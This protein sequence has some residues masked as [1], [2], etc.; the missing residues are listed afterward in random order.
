M[1][2]DE[3]LVQIECDS[4]KC[5]G[6]INEFLEQGK[7]PFVIIGDYA[8]SVYCP[9]KRFTKDIDIATTI[10]I[11]GPLVG[12]L[13]TLGFSIDPFHTNDKILKASKSNEPQNIE[14]HVSI[15]EVF[16]ETTSN[17]YPCKELLANKKYLEINPFFSDCDK[18]KTE[19]PVINPND[20]FILKAMTNRDRDLIDC[21]FYLTSDHIDLE[22]ISTKLSSFT[23]VKNYMI[24]RFTTV[25]KNIR[26]RQNYP[27][28]LLREINITTNY[29]F[30][31]QDI[32]NLLKIIKN[33]ISLM[34]D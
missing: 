9:R 24:G 18:Y 28:I 21:F 25:L 20:A 16:D 29:S 2:I 15:D 27:N 4:L 8:I 19:I 32:Q 6:E 12:L 22:T 10:D 3:R 14:L 26:S 17:S 13:K 30:S 34:R 5:L 33:L 7:I 31:T 1:A 23:Q 11:V